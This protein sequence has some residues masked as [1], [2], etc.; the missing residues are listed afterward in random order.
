M[1]PWRERGFPRALG[2][3]MWLG[4]APR[5]RNQACKT[6]L[7][8]GHSGMARSFRPLPLRWT[9]VLTPTATWAQRR[10]V[11]FGDAGATVIHGQQEGMIAS[12]NPRRVIGPARIA[13]ISSR[14]IPNQLLLLAF[15]GNRQDP[16][17]ESTRSGSRSATN[18]KKLRIAERRMFRDQTVLPRCCSGW[19]KRR[20][21]WGR[22]A[23]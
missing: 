11:E 22:P 18:Q 13:S 2:N 19:V 3:A 15:D 14:A 6:R 5:S 4:S 23:P 8:W 12:S 17:D 20:E 16:R 10:A 21:W 7:V 1:T 9:K